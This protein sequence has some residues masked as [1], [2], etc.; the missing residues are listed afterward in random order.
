MVRARRCLVVAVA[1]LAGGAWASA[2]APPARYAGAAGGA[3]SDT[4]PLDEPLSADLDGDGAKETV[5]AEE[6]QCFTNDGPKPPPCERGG[7]RSLYVTVQDPCASGPVKLRLSREMDL[8]S[9]AEV[10][11]ADR[12]GSKDDLAFETRAGASSQGVQAKVV[13]FMADANGCIAVQKTLFSYPRNATIGERPKGMFFRTGFLS[14]HDFDKGIKG[15][16]LR[17][18]EFYA[19]AADPGCCPRYGRTTFWRYVAG[20]SGYTPYRTKLRKI[21]KPFQSSSSATSR[22]TSTETSSTTSGS[23]GSG[24]AAFTDTAW[25]SKSLSRRSAIAAQRR[26]SVLSER[27]VATSAAT[28]QT[29]P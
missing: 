2:A 27:W 19:R 6:T 26:S 20:R 22:Q 12:D 14:I 17:T 15:L 29:R 10:V 8:V 25:A 21:P 1:L 13:R 7:Q 23:G 5:V 11:D 28:S 4:F 9:L 18:E 24:L 16:E 3:Q